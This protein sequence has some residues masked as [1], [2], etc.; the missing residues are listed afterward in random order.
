MTNEITAEN[1]KTEKGK[2]FLFLHIALLCVGAAIYIPSAFFDALWFDEAYTVGLLSR[3]LFELVRWSVHDVHPPLYYALLKIFTLPF[4]GTVISMRLL[5]AACY[6]L[7]AAIG[8]SHIRK[9]FGEKTGLYFTFFSLFLGAGLFYALQ[10]RMY[11]L[12]CVFVTLAAVYARRVYVAPCRK[13]TALFVLFSVL[14]AYTHHFALFTVACVNLAMLSAEKKR[15]GNFKNWWGRAWWQIGC[16]LPGA[17]IFLYQIVNGGASWITFDSPDWVF[18]FCFY[19]FAGKQL[20]DVIPHGTVAYYAAGGGLVALWTAAVVFTVNLFQKKKIKL[21]ATEYALRTIG[22]LLAIT[23]FVSFFR[24]V[25][26]VRYTMTFFGLTC[27][28]FAS[29]L[30]AIGSKRVKAAVLCLIAAAFAGNGY[31]LEKADFSSGY[32]DM[33]AYVSEDLKEGDIFFSDNC[34][35]YVFTVSFPEVTCYFANC[36]GW[37]VEKAYRAFGENC[38][39]VPDVDCEELTSLGGRVWV[40]SGERTE[41]FLSGREEWSLVK[42]E[43]FHTE[44][45]DKTYRV[46][47]YEKQT[48]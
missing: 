48:D 38:Y 8:L 6:L 27:F 1:K 25:Y 30:S 33:I 32:D 34:V 47:L 2:L 17:A 16:Y 19:P 44:Y 46:A 12:A 24:P 11:S 23:I 20:E 29:A 15:F 39:V 26:Y 35:E 43:T 9:D 4:G 18:D 37:H 14:S 42:S 45:Q 40:V 36:S 28:V 41:A 31:F 22:Y 10:I 5:S 7:F 13:N 21:P 3:N